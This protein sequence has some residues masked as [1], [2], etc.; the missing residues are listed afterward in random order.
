MR[1]QTALTTCA[2]MGDGSQGR[3]T[4]KAIKSCFIYVNIYLV[5]KIPRLWEKIGVCAAENSKTYVIVVG[6]VSDGVRRVRTTLTS[7]AAMGDGAKV[8]R[9]LSYI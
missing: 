2:A 4:N 1:N 6:E 9:T 5:S 7:C 8:I 3:L